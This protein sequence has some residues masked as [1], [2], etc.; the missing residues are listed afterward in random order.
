MHR[1][2]MRTALALAEKGR[3]YTS[4]N[5]RVGAV[6]VR[7]GQVVGRGFHERYGGNHAEVNALAEA[8]ER[9]RGATLFVT[10]EPC[11]IWG[12]TPPCTEAII[13]AGI[14]RVVVP[15][16]DP[17]P[18]IAGRGLAALRRAGVEVELGLLRDEAIR[19]NAPYLKFRR[20]G[21]PY[22][23][24]KL[25]VSLDGRVATRDGGPLAISSDESR[26]LVHRMRSEADAVLIGIGTVLTD[27]PRLTDRRPEGGKRQPAR[28]V[29]DSTLRTPETAK[30]LVG[31]G[32][33]RTIIAARLETPAERREGIERA[34]AELWTAAAGDGGL[35]LEEVLRRAAGEGFI[36]IL[37]EGGPRLATSLLNAGFIDRISFFVAPS[38]IGA[39][40]PGAL[41][42]LQFDDIIFSEGQWTTVGSDALFEADIRRPGGTEAGR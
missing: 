2:Y 10:L 3:G 22:V 23:H 37:C 5:P 29:V 15:I 31:T 40:A 26:A 41:G 6:L 24:L 13:T 17:N 9:A 38:L 25:A 27:N 34:G 11:S 4:P 7:D 21:F 16:E 18:E 1:E 32:E 20:T 33:H 8:G 14:T 28:I 12:K 39:D 19:L 42:R 35:D 36:D 30:L